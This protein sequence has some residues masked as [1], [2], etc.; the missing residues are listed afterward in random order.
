MHDTQFYAQM[1]LLP[2]R[3]ELARRVAVRAL[4]G[5]HFMP[6][7]LLESQLAI[8]DTE[9]PDV[10]V[11]EGNTRLPLLCSILACN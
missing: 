10:T 2:S 8:L 4:V 5:A 1:L 6:A 3:S 9:G 7:D 11:I